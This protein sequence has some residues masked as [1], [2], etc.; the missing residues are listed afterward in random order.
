MRETFP[1][2]I[3]I[4]MV[5]PPNLWTV[6]G[7]ATQLHQVLMNLCVNARDAMP[8]GG[9][10]T[11][12]A[13]NVTLGEAEVR[14]HP[15]AHPGNYTVLSVSDTGQ[16]IPPEI[17]ARIFDPFFTTKGV[18]KGTGLGL[19]TVH[20]I[21]KAHGGFVTVESEVDKGTTFRV[22]LPADVAASAPVAAP[23]DGALVPGL[24]EMILVVDDEADVR[25]AI[26]QLLE[27]QR[28]RVIT[29]G[30]GK[31]ALARFVE[32][33]D[34]VQLLLTDVM[35][36]EMGGLALI[37]GAKA[38]NQE[39]RV[40]AMTGLGDEVTKSELAAI[41]VTDVVLKPYTPRELLS[42]VQ[43]RLARP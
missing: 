17:I 23:T 43:E 20:G 9:E 13:A 15:S 40:V 8:E 29:A 42:K 26:V 4:S 39:L 2:E 25:A 35:M 30:N 31:E 27:R 38:L 10:L 3:K 16:G 12:G 19:S 7:D 6:S 14:R 41:G 18:G 22:Y 5:A 21:A 24:G 1:R 34:K 32:F 28:Y 37:R 33:G 11:V 36:P